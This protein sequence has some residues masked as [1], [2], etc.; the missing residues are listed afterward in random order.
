MYLLNNKIT[1]SIK[2]QDITPQK[3]KRKL[4]IK[5]LKLVILPILGNTHDGS[6]FFQN[7]SG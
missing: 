1:I 5:H 7:V 3:Q 6:F 2:W 4:L